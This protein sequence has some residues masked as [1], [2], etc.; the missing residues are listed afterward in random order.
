MPKVKLTC[1]YCGTDY[2]KWPH[3]AKGSK[4]CSYRCRMTVTQKQT[5]VVIRERARARRPVLKQ[6]E[7]DEY[8]LINVGPL[9]AAMVDIQDYEAVDNILWSMGTDGYA[10]NQNR[11]RLS[12]HRFILERKIGRPLTRIELADHEDHDRLNCRR[13]NLRLA[14]AGNNVANKSRPSNNTSG[15]KGVYFHIRRHKYAA[16]I[17]SDGSSIHLGLFTDPEQA[18]LAYDAAAIQLFGEFAYTNII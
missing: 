6:P 11:R 9:H 12:L 7:R 5:V 14:T 18:A 1:Q 16:G 10:Y 2:L 17:A 8:R 4:Y 3:A 13:Y 15:Y